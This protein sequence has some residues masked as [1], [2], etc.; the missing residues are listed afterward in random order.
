MNTSSN[1][2]KTIPVFRCGIGACLCVDREGVDVI[3][4]QSDHPKNRI[5]LTISEY[6][7]WVSL[8]QPIEPS[9]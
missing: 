4:Y 1:R 3:V 5:R 8:A 9:P 7:E 2:F 6:N